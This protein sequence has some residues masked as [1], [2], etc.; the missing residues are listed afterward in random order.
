MAGRYLDG[1][2]PAPAAGATSHPGGGLVGDAR[3]VPRARSRAAC[4]HDAL[5]VLWEFVGGANKTVD[6][7]QPWVLAK[8][9]TAGD[10]SRGRT[11]VAASSATSSRPAG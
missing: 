7:E 2:R 11:P 3:P 4:L 8:A 1:D 5:A 10:A 9:A 6:A